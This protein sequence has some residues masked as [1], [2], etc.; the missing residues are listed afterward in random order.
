MG[1]DR[2]LDG[3]LDADL[4]APSLQIAQASG[5]A[6]LHWP[7]SATGFTLESTPAIAPT[8]WTGV[9]D[10]WSIVAGQNYVTNAPANAPK[11]Y[12]LRR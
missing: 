1:I 12:R 3:V 9:P 10:P 5:A 2:D 11:F 6:V 4:T 7:F 8:A